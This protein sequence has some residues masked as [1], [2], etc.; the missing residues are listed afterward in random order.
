MSAGSRRVEPDVFDLDA[1]AGQRR[2]G[3]HP[4]RG[5]GE[6]AGNRQRPAASVAAA[7]PSRPSSPSTR[8]DRAESR[9]R[10]LGV[11][12]GL[13]PARSP[14]S[15]RRRAARRAAPPTSP[16]RWAPAGDSAI[17]LQRP[18]VD[19]QR[20]MAVGRFDAGAHPFERLDDAPHRAPRQRRVADQVLVN[21]WPPG[22][23]PAFAS[24]CRNCRRRAGT[25]V[26]GAVRCLVRSG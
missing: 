26:N 15:C 19:R 6:V 22:C 9:E 1:R 7:L 17:G 11:V 8:N 14:R 16:G 2:G 10:A 21:G 25:R 4:E 24:S 12:A 23:P 3:D 20:G 13:R 5:G 18:P